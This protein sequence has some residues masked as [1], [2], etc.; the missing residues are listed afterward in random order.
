MNEEIDT[1]E[2][3]DVDRSMLLAN[4]SLARLYPGIRWSD[5][6][7]EMNAELEQREAA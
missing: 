7:A 1:P 4:R 2:E 6:V 3:I 5:V